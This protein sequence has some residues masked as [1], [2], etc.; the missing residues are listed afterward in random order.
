MYA[1]KVPSKYFGRNIP[2]YF[3]VPGTQLIHK[4]GDETLVV[5]YLMNVVENTANSIGLLSTDVARSHRRRGYTITGK[6]SM[7]ID[8]LRSSIKKMNIFYRFENVLSHCLL[9]C[10]KTNTLGPYTTRFTREKYVILRPSRRSMLAGSG[11]NA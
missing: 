9:A 10:L 6:P 5:F 1:K 7:T 4:N 11:L 8:R 2:L 3:N